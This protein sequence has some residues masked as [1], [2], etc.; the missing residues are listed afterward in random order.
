VTQRVVL[1]TVALGAT[2]YLGLDEP[3]SVTV[4]AG[5]PSMYRTLP[6]PPL[7]RAGVV[8]GPPPAWDA[9][10]LEVYG[11]TETC[12]PVAMT[13]P[14]AGGA[15]P[16]PGL[17]V[18]VVDDGADVA[19]GQEGEV[20]VSGP[21]VM[22]G[23][24]HNLPADTA[25]S[26]RDGWYRTGDLARRDEWG[27]LRPTGRAADLI[28]HAGE[29]INPRTV[30]AAL[31]T[32]VSDAAVIDRD[33]SP[34]AYVVMTT[35]V[36]PDA[37]LTACEGLPR[38]ARPTEY[39]ATAHLPRTVGDSVVRHALQNQ[40]A[41]L[42]ALGAPPEDLY[43]PEWTTLT[44]L[45]VPGGR[46]DF[47]GPEATPASGKSTADLRIL[48]GADPLQLAAD[49]SAWPGTPHL[50]IHTEGALPIL[51]A[52]AE[53]RA[54]VRAAG[55]RHPGR[56]TLVDTEAPGFGG[57]DGR[58]ELA[59]P[60]A[61]GTRGVSAAAVAGDR[62]ELGGPTSLGATDLE[63]ILASGAAEV[64][65]RAGTVLVSRLAPVS[66]TEQRPGWRLDP[67][68]TVVLRGESAPSVA[69][70]R[71][72]VQAYG[73]RDLVVT[74]DPGVLA[75]LDVTAVVHEGAGA[76]DFHRAAPDAYFVH[77][78]AGA[79]PGLSIAWGETEQDPRTLFDAATIAGGSTYV[80]ARRDVDA[81]RTHAVLTDEQLD[82]LVWTEI[83]AIVDTPRHPDRAFADLGFDS[84][85]AVELRNRLSAAT[86][87]RLP[88]TL[89]LDHPTPR[90]LIAK[91]GAALAG[92][93]EDEP[94]EKARPADEPVA[95]VGMA[96]RLPGG[97]RSPADLWRL[98][99]DGGDGI[100]PFPTNRGWDTE[101]VFDPDPD[102][103]GKSYVREGGFLHDADEFDAGFFGISPREAL[104]MDPQQ[105]FLLETSWEALEHAGIDPTGLK[106]SR[107]G[108]F[109]GMIAQDYGWGSTADHLLTG[110]KASVA[111]GR[112]AY[113]LGLEGPAVTIDTA[114]SASLVALHLAAQAIR[115]GECDLALAGGVTVMSSTE[116]FVEFSRQRGLAPDGR[117]KAFSGSADGTAWSEGVGVLV[118]ERLSDARRNGH[119]VLAV[120]RG[121][122][123]NQD[124]ASNGL[125]APNGP[126]QQRVIR[127]AL[128][129]AGLSTQDVDAVEAHGTGTTLGDP[130]EAQALLATYGRHRDRPLWLGSLKSNIGHAQAAAGVAGVI[131]MVLAMRHGRLPRT[132]HV[133]EPTPEVD[134]SAGNVALL[135]E[136][137]EWPEPERPRRAAVSSFG[138]SGTNAHV[139]I[140]QGPPVAAA[141]PAEWPP[142]VPWVLSGKTSSALPAQAA[143]LVEVDDVNL[144][145]LGFS[146]ATTRAALDHR[147][148]VLGADRAELLAGLRTLAAGERSPNVVTGEVAP[149]KLALL[150]T[151]QGSQRVGMAADLR[152]QFPVFAKA[153]DEVCGFFP[154]ALPLDDEDELNRTGYTQAA[155]FAVEVGLF[156][157]FESWG[158]RP[159]FL[160]GH[161]IGE[162][163]AAYVAGVWSLADACRVVVARGRLMQA[164]PPGGA[165]L[166]VRATEDEVAPLM[167]DR[168]AIAAINGPRSV[169][170]SGDAG[171]L[172]ELAQR[173]T[174]EE[175][176]VKRLT[177]SH[178]FHS[179]L[180]DPM[181]AEFRAVLE[182]VS[183]SEPTIPVVVNG[184][185]TEPQF[186]VRHVRETVRFA[187][188]IAELRAKGVTTFLEL[189]P[190]AVL[191]GMG[192]DC[193]EDPVFVPAMRR[194]RDET[195]T[196]LRA[197][198]QL[199]TRGV[200]V[201]WAAVFPG[202][203]P[204]ELPTYA[205]Q[206]ERFWLTG[207]RSVDP[208]GL[209][210]SPTE[211]PLLGA[212]VSLAGGDTTVF[213][214]RLSLTTHPWLADHAVGGTVLVPGTVF[215]EMAI[216]A[217]DHVDRPCLDELTLHA[218]LVLD[219]PVQVQ[220]TV[221]GA[222]VTVHSR[223]E[224]G[225]WT[226]HASGTLTADTPR[227]DTLAEWPP[228]GA[229]AV[230]VEGFYDSLGAFGYG[231]AFRGLRAAWRLGDDVYTE[232]ALP[233]S[234]RAKG[235]G[236]HP[237]LLDAAMHG[238][239]LRD[240]ADTRLPF[241]WTGVSLHAAGATT[242]RVRLRGNAVTIADPTGAPVASIDALALR[243]VDPT[244]LIPRPATD[245]WLF[246][247]EWTPAP[248]GG[249]APTSWAVLGDRLSVAGMAPNRY[250]TLAALAATLDSGA[251]A[252]EVVVCEAG[253]G[254]NGVAGAPSA[255]TATVLAQ[256]WLADERLAGS[257]LVLV[258]RG[259]A[260]P[261]TTDPAGAAVWG[262][263]RSTQTEHPDRF[264]LLDTDSDILP[265]TLDE[266]QL[267]LRDG[268]LLVPRLTRLRSGT[269]DRPRH[270]TVLV[271]GG[272]GGL[273]AVVARHL[274]ATHG[275]RRLVLLSR[276]GPAAPGADELIALGAEVRACDV[277]D[278]AA[279]AAVINAIPDLTGV[280]H[281]A[282]VL[283]DG[284]IESLTPQRLDTV[285]APKADAAWHLHELTADHDLTL[286]ALF[287]SASGILGTAGQ[288]NYAA[289]NTY[290]D[291]LAHRRH[292]Q[293]RPATSLAWGPWD[294]GMTADLAKLARG[295]VSPL[296]TSEGL[297]LFD[298]ALATGAPVVVPIKLDPARSDSPLVRGRGRRTAT[299]EG[300][301]SLRE[302]VARLSTVEQERV[303]RDLVREQVAAVLGHGSPAAIAPDRPFD[304]L[305]FD[306]LTAVELRNQ[307]NDVTGLRLP[308]TLIFDYPTPAAVADAVR[309]LLTAAEPGA[310]NTP[311]PVRN[312]E[313]ELIDAM[314]ADSLVRRALRD[315]VRV[316]A[317]NTR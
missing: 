79:G 1:G 297:A 261:D 207:T 204:V 213:T 92:T 264:V 35:P 25:A 64:A 103:A 273:G 179:P 267:V 113:V 53:I 50:V 138:I 251:R 155:L 120:V 132:L 295:G 38:A 163:T 279:L 218:P 226:R 24:Y 111:S 293:G 288:A 126:S 150:C 110:T 296:S 125:T 200:P 104:A 2:A 109:A 23:G 135:T 209:G 241:A 49:L 76:D 219:G 285:F 275:V 97:V 153:F 118:V 114:C 22:A 212:A 20:W 63:Q 122:A 243:T 263:I 34:I 144:A 314:D 28:V 269:V 80:V 291:A 225:V 32:V 54:L 170:V 27:Y 123:V 93:V 202:A 137:R 141:P 9:P 68:G 254:H 172:D 247:V 149:G 180:M 211:H 102:R 81:G 168:V 152:R 199:H 181:L 58:G 206:R 174:A 52:H 227:G 75:G 8:F 244:Q 265:S 175:R 143:R 189:G 193:A 306:S 87:L 116:P 60:D 298:A 186:W 284:A 37:L 317:V 290:L 70:A 214:G 21:S 231:P 158:I 36:T 130:I 66:L 106:G 301:T 182:T 282:G 300:A 271:T 133:T 30:E 131:K 147:A 148:V 14:G 82:S 112:I 230:A 308:A 234:L 194:D 266:P 139:I 69:I 136:S 270:G 210:Q 65:V 260:G 177:V 156:R 274:V 195:A 11:S 178:A 228:A 90:A 192:A 239:L 13:W 57:V 242:L 203:R 15:M 246:G 100:T 45:S 10:L 115:A 289:A 6:V 184:N 294:Q 3:E 187:D 299:P 59:A 316:R 142:V 216:R 83:A 229:E 255:H 201:D 315:R 43:Q 221:T 286:F 312:N 105:R 307:L 61:A 46:L 169:V 55:T 108:V 146:L 167:T 222:A 173:W 258:T 157:L 86:G 292:A 44:E 41:H 119:R 185:P 88:T 84:L 257:R 33:G 250:D 188:G 42:C 233:E 256:Q 223:P 4:L 197:L 48:P 67:D 262:L 259:A 99:A 277:T 47:G 303:L 134:W 17:G 51:P 26:L 96:C 121:S 183:F 31:R 245:R 240:G 235:F 313:T 154:F 236:I 62:G 128:A 12:G 278:R 74:D 95:I 19:T 280:V 18:R 56:I 205:F 171:V 159:D 249:S 78:G 151:G 40:P 71:H 16:L 117:C 191:S 232:V 248:A 276:R 160:A 127:Q 89:V 73:A 176:K 283:A 305:G 101:S 208:A 29:R 124:G 161:S 302:R 72:L 287:S 272:T 190:D 77:L 309:D 39:Y 220:V 164:L 198:A 196:V 166:S 91:L 252:P 129:G 162:L 217:G 237:A 165:M 140:E 215:V 238:L 94:A 310:V 145:D 253:A 224:D 98:V 268:R 5:P 304:G 107:T 7:L 85:A 311:E 281:T